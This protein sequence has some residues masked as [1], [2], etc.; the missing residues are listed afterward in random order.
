M[1]QRIRQ[2]VFV[3]LMMVA[4]IMTFGKANQV[5]AKI[6]FT[7]DTILYKNEPENAKPST[8]SY[9]T[10]INKNG[11]LIYDDDTIQHLDCIIKVTTQKM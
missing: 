8:F 7:D 6:Q 3:I 10:S 4:G 1:L 9:I 11:T 5:E 2:M